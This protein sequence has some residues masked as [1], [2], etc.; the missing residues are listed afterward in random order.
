MVAKTDIATPPR[1]RAV[2]SVMCWPFFILTQ[3]RGYECVTKMN[4]P[5]E[6]PTGAC[7]E[8]NNDPASW[9]GAGADPPERE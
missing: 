2:T 1:K 7:S 3:P 8:R 4:A 5:A 6:P 9:A